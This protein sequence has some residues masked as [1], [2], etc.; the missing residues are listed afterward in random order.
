M[1][2]SAKAVARDGLTGL[3]LAKPHCCFDEFCTFSLAWLPLTFYG[4]ERT[5]MYLSQRPSCMRYTS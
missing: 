3:E 1:D 2:L 4:A 5:H